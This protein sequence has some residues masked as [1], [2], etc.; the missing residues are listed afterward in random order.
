MGYQGAIFSLFYYKYG[1]EANLKAIELDGPNG[2]S[3]QQLLGPPRRQDKLVKQ[4]K[5]FLQYYYSLYNTFRVIGIE[6]PDMS[7]LGFSTVTLCAY[8]LRFFV[9]FSKE[10][11][12]PYIWL[13]PVIGL[14]IAIG[15]YFFVSKHKDSYADE[16]ELKWY[17]YI[18]SWLFTVLTI[19]FIY[20][21]RI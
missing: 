3:Q 9:I 18:I 7:A 21:D 6:T 20:F 14:G 16:M 8:I 10:S 5:C 15:I 2:P 17:H 1:R 4:M 12:K 13:A 19:Y 11:L